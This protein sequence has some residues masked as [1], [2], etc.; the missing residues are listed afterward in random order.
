MGWEF[1]TS[2]VIGL[3]GLFFSILAFISARKARDAAIS[4]ARKVAG[5][6]ISVELAE[7]ITSLSRLDAQSDYAVF[8]QVLLENQ[9]RAVRS[10]SQL[11][12]GEKLGVASAALLEAFEVAT[13]KLRESQPVGKPGRG[14]AGVIFNTLEPFIQAIMLAVARVQSVLDADH[15]AQK[16]VE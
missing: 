10:L 13:E 14:P 6:S 9:R 12:S 1:V 5:Y 11:G 3:L 7:V 4:A 2:T 16:V 8:R 15:V